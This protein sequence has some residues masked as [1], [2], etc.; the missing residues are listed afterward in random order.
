MRKIL[1]LLPVSLAMFTGCGE[2]EFTQ[3]KY[4]DLSEE[5]LLDDKFNETDMR[6]IA[7]TMIK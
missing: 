7:E 6:M 2:R 3:G 1:F 4:D 5:R